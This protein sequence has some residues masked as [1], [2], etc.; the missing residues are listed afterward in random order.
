MYVAIEYKQWRIVRLLAKKGVPIKNLQNN[1][2][3]KRHQMHLDCPFIVQ[4]AK[5][6]DYQTFET[7]QSF[8]GE[9]NDTGEIGVSN[10]HNNIVISNILGAIASQ[11][12]SSFLK[13][14]IKKMKDGLEFEAIEKQFI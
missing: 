2:K 8:G 13:K 11:D 1:D 4:A 6:S 5:H 12:N 7:V 9:I 14:V 3:L 10:T